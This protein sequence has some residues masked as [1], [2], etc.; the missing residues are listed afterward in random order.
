MLQ[1]FVLREFYFDKN[2]FCRKPNPFGF[3]TPSSVET[4]IA[5]NTRGRKENFRGNSDC[6]ETVQSG[7][8]C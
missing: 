5:M 6:T 4:K 3:P 7:E 2:C 8:L 1:K